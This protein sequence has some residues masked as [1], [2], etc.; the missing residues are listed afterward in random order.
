M[1]EPLRHQNVPEG[2]EPKTPAPVEISAA[3]PPELAYQELASS[4]EDSARFFWRAVSRSKLLILAASVLVSVFVFLYYKAQTPL[5]RAE[6]K[7]L[8]EPEESEAAQIVGFV[9]R[10]S[11]HETDMMTEKDVIQSRI[12]A[13]RVV[14]TLELK[15]IPP[16]KQLQ[17]PAG[18]ILSN[19]SVDASLRSRA[20]SVGFL[21]ADPSLAAKIADE[22]VNAYI[23][24]SEEKTRSWMMRTVEQMRAEA[25]RLKQR[26][27]EDQKKLKQ[28]EVEHPKVAATDALEKHIQRL[29]TEL[30]KVSS[31]KLDFKTQLEEL[32]AFQQ[33][34]ADVRD[35][36][37]I[38]KDPS[39]T[40]TVHAIQQKQVELTQLLTIYKEQFPLVIEKRNE[41]ATLQEI[42][43][44]RKTE[45]IEDLKS[46][47]LLL[48]AREAEV[49]KEID[50]KNAE[51][52]TL[53]GASGPYEVLLGEA[54]VSKTL[55]ATLIERMDKA[56][57]LGRSQQ[58]R[59][60]VLSRA[61]VP[62]KPHWP[63]IERNTSMTFVIALAAFSYLAY[64]FFLM[65]KPIES[66][67]E[68]SLG[69]KIPVLAQVPHVSSSKGEGGELIVDQGEGVGKDALHF[70][71]AALVASGQRAFVF[72]S[73]NPSEGKTFV[74]H[75]LGVY[76]AREGKR[77]LVVGSDFRDLQLR[78]R[79]G[80][81]VGEKC[82]AN[83]LAGHFEAKD[84]IHETKE[85]GL[86]YLG[87]TEVLKNAVEVIA[88]IK[89]EQLIRGLMSQFDF[90]LLDSPPVGLFPDAMLLTNIVQNTVFV[91]RFGKTPYRKLAKSTH[92]IQK[93]GGRLTG[94][95]LND[96]TMGWQNYYYYNYYYERG[97]RRK[98]L[99][100]FIRE[101]DQYVAR[102]R[103]FVERRKHE[104][105][106][107]ALPLEFVCKTSDGTEQHFWAIATDL[108]EGGMLAEYWNQSQ[109]T[110]G[111]LE[112]IKEIDL[113]M[114][115]PNR[116]HILA[117]GKITRALIRGQQIH[118]GVQFID[119]SDEDRAKVKELL[120]KR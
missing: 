54:Q 17:D 63:Q 40:Q 110:Q 92:E 45:I 12:V 107:T 85:P 19:M 53:I 31:E 88:S 96:K 8:I 55:Y 46:N 74:V 20:V 90:V 18:L 3:K 60:K 52:S 14:E 5:Y 75:N 98:F 50:R 112:Q 58:S 34:G 10:S 103:D 108:S 71:R 29:S 33:Q 64:L 102:V 44:Q 6:V 69:I 81:E 78:A 119:I 80:V 93:N 23:E 13:E 97:G 49:Q 115:L 30:T 61:R 117:K 24:I 15:T 35:H 57:I 116:D 72:T 68:I 56:G 105:F 94:A 95:V 9:Q 41:L 65:V 26:L 109:A 120:D 91:V 16:F 32:A 99:P 84:I 101:A 86:F 51:L 28:Y 1:G 73:T 43:G 25:A 38:A 21:F 89:F 77:I 42:L 76:L 36:P 111:D 104:R 82:I 106:K 22:I 62:R 4:I 47:Y 70:L 79:L 83:Y 7:V 87:P 114:R 27:D 48:A 67:E 2:E 66:E 113:K 37:S 11:Q 118:L 100:R 39:I 59:V